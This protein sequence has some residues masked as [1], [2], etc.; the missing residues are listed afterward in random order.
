MILGGRQQSILRCPRAHSAHRTNLLILPIAYLSH[1]FVDERV[2]GYW[3]GG[4]VGGVICP[5]PEVL[6]GTMGLWC[7]NDEQWLRGNNSYNKYG[8]TMILRW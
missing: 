5:Q 7:H 2:Q 4:S 8:V 3:L 6:I 1:Q